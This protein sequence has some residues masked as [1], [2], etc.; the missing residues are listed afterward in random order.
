L[1]TDVILAAE[2]YPTDDADTDT[3]VDSVVAARINVEQAGSETKLDEV[4]ADKGYQGAATLETSRR[5]L[6]AD[7]YPRAEAALS[8]VVDLT[9]RPN[10]SRPCM[11]T[12]A[13]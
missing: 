2:I 4:V 5:A 3:L 6:D 1:K 7:L 12:G 10:F 11:P 9:S 13:I 8:F